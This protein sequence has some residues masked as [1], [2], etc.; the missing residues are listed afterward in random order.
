MAA[1]STRS[2]RPVISRLCAAIPARCASVMGTACPS[3]QMRSHSGSSTSGAPLVYCT[4]RPPSECRVLIILRALSNGASATRGSCA[5]SALGDSPCVTA[6]RTSAA[7]VGSPVTVSVSGSCTASAHSAMAV[8]SRRSSLPADAVTVMRFCVSVPVLSVQMICAQPSVSTAVSRRMTALR[9][10]M[11]VT[12]IDSTIV[13]T[14]ASPSG[15]AATA[16]LTAMRNVSSTTRPLIVPARSTPTANTIAQM[17]STSHVRMRLSCDRRSC[18]GV[19]FSFV[20]VSASA[21][22]PICVC[23]PVPVTTARPR[24]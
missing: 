10:L 8:A 12:P 22:C 11:F 4:M 16:R 19:L 5:R 9:R 21:I 14:A 13:T 7:S 18:S 24:P 23:M 1:A 20:C 17:P 3:I 15:M 2:A 6:Q